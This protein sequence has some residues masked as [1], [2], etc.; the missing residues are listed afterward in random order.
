L[1]VVQLGLWE[2]YNTLTFFTGNGDG[3][4]AALPNPVSGFYFTCAG[5]GDFNGDGRPDLA[6]TD[7]IQSGY[8]V[9]VLLTET[10]TATASAS[11]SLP[12]NTGTHL[13]DASYSGD[14]DYSPSVSG[15][16][17]LLTTGMVSLSATGLS[18]GDEP[19]N[20]STTAQGVQ[21][22]NT[23]VGTLN[24][25]SIKLKGTNATSFVTSNTCGAS[26]AVGATCQVGVRFTPIAAGP[27]SAA[28]TLTDSGTDSPQSVTLSGTGI[29]APTASLKITYLDILFGNESVSFGNE[30]VGESTGSVPVAVTNTSSTAVLYFK[31]I[32]LEGPDASSFVTSN[33]CGG[34]MGAVLNPGATCRIGVRFVPTRVGAANATITL[35]DNTSN[36]PQTINLS[37][38]G[39]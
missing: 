5:V 34:S 13:V 38:T 37:G 3:T 30:P 25:A 32:A 35:T 4:F 28:V 11:I 2:Y 22:T 19:V 10:Q 16:T 33:T 27:A 7:G 20:D 21:V 24:I 29:A 36:S 15:T 31:T 9:A 23:G 8:F 12:S 14:S 6:V 17:G 1:A 18:F 26:L 39:Q